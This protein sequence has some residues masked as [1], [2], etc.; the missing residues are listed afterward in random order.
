MSDSLLLPVVGRGRVTH[1]TQNVPMKGSVRA[2]EG[3][4][5]GRSERRPHVPV[6]VVLLVGLI[7]SEFLLLVNGVAVTTLSAS[8]ATMLLGVDIADRL[9]VLPGARRS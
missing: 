2:P 5:T 3:C 7:V 8:L 1:M 4:R 9:S 6:L